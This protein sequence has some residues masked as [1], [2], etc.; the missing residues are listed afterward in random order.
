MSEKLKTGDAQPELYGFL[1]I[2]LLHFLHQ[3]GDVEGV[4]LRLYFESVLSIIEQV[5][6]RAQQLTE[7]LFSQN[8]R[9]SD[10]LYSKA[11][12]FWALAAEAKGELPS[13][14]R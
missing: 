12:Y 11:V 10:W 9:S 2:S 14:L 5:G 6:N 1:S 4:R 13:L 8:R 7:L 3:A